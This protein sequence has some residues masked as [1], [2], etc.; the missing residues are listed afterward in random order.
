MQMTR[1]EKCF[2]LPSLAVALALAVSARAQVIYPIQLIGFVN[3]RFE[4]GDNLFGNPLDATNNFLS[5]ICPSA[6]GLI[7]DGT[8][9]S[10]W[11]PA[12][13]AFL[14][15]SIFTAG[16][17]WSID[18]V[19]GP[20]QGA[21]L[22]APSTFTNTFVGSVIYVGFDSSMNLIPASPSGLGQG[23]YLLSSITPLRA[24]PFEVVTGRLPNEGD[25]VTR[26][27]A[28]TQ[29][30]STTTFRSGFWD[31]DTPTLGTGEAA[32]YTLAS[33]PEPSLLSLLGLA[34]VGVMVA[35]RQA[36]ARGKKHCGGPRREDATSP[37]G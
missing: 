13:R 36:E 3:Q 21:R 23:V 37:C 10:P 16:Q 32:F 12:A 14:P 31:N 7:P 11:D 24:A 22:W 9:M 20:G 30:Y 4:A 6:A 27:D 19:L 2:K 25:Q 5:T 34:L 8:I 17:G 33:V 35:K 18:Y 1:V 28:L 15:G 26:L 29:T